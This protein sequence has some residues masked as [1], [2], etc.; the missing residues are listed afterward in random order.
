MQRPSVGFGKWPLN[1]ISQAEP[2]LRHSQEVFLVL[3]IGSFVRK[4]IRPMKWARQ[5]LHG[6]CQNLDLIRL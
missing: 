1:T 4:I 3:V 5:E 6:Q 2:R